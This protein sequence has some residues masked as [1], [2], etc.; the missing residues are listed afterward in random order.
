MEEAQDVAKKL[1]VDV[2]DS[3][4]DQGL[5]IPPAVPAEQGD[6]LIKLPLDASIKILL[7]N[8]MVEAKCS[9]ADLAR[10]LNVPPQRIKGFL[11]LLKSTNLEFLTRAF[12][13]LGKTVKVEII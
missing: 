2:I 4:F 6:F 13:F 1:L 5:N 12:D 3:L 10:G 8:C 7:R 11:S 9:K